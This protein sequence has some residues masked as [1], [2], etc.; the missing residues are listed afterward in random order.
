M[1]RLLAVLAVIYV[2]L[3]LLVYF[4]QRSLLYF[5]THEKVSTSLAPWTNNGQLIGCCREASNP[6]AVWLMMHGNG[7]QA[8]H[9]D[10]VL[11][12]L[13]ERD[14]IYVLEYPGYGSRPG[15]PSLQSINAAAADAYK[16]LRQRFPRAPVCV[17]G[18]SLGSGPACFLAGE[19]PPP[20]KIVLIVPFDNLASVASA[21]FYWLP[22]RLLL[23]D[24]WDNVESLK[25]YSGPV[26]IFG[27]RE[28]NIIPVQ[29]ARSL[30]ARVPQAR[31]TEIEGGHNDWSMTRQVKINR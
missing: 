21:M 12:C 13:S 15:S 17:I 16:A 29:H 31:F 26:D 23:S 30:A 18:E 27:A 4:R 11:P 24:A 7:G 22:V 28:D 14:S 19:K 9:R 10:Y 25:N 6:N 20:D 3:L 5:P 2:L 8:E 1:L